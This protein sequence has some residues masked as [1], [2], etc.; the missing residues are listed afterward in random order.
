MT[1]ILFLM[2]RIYRN[3]FKCNYLKNILFCLNFLLHI[4][5][6]HQ[7]MKILRKKRSLTADVFPKLDISKRVVRQMSEKSRFRVPFDSQHVKGS[8]P[9]PKS[10]R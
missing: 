4:R 9:L 5:N 8:Q 1:S 6:L 7:P 2:V 10:E 3:Q